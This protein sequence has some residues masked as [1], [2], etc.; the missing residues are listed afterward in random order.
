MRKILLICLLLLSSQSYAEEQKWFLD[1]IKVD[2]PNQLGYWFNVDG[3][4]P[5]TNVEGQK[6]IE[7]V[8][9]RSRIKPLSSQIFSEETYLSIE[10]RCINL[11]KKSPAYSIE[12]FF[13]QYEPTPILF[14]RS[15]GG[16]GVNDKDGISGFLKD[17]TEDAITVFI[18]A[19]F[20][21]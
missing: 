18:K 16:F 10:L 3:D 5:I 4:C 17:R 14:D 1:A 6:I 21:L 9:I 20:N 13:G 19:N 15:F 12:M 8:F 7:G 11:N 2:N